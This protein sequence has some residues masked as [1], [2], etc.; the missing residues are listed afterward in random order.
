VGI[1]ATGLRVA[2]VALAVAASAVAVPDPPAGTV[3]EQAS[4]TLIEIPVNVLGRDGLPISGLEAKDFELFVD[5]KKEAPNAVEAIDLAAQTPAETPAGAGAAVPASAR[6]LWLLV[7]D[8]SYTSSSGLIRAR[9]GARHFVSTSMPATDLAAVGTLSIDTGWKLLVNF[10]RDRPQLEAAIATLGLPGLAVAS[11]DPLGFA[12][13][14]PGT[15]GS[16][17]GGLASGGKGIKEADVEEALRE[18][19]QIQR[20]SSDEQQRARVGKLMGSLG[21]IGR[22]LDS[23]RGRKHVVYF[24]EGFDPR[25][26]A[27]RSG[28]ASPGSSQTQLQM[29]SSTGGAL[30]PGTTLGANEA[31]IS[32]EIWKVDSDARFGSSSLQ[33]R[34]TS[35]LGLLGRSDAVLDAI[36][37]GGL[38]ADGD[39]AGARVSGTDSLAA[40]ASETGG[41][42]VRNANS[43]GEELHRVAEKTRRVYLLVYQPKGASKPG[44]F[45]RLRVAVKAPGAHV[46][47]RSGYYEPRPYASLTPL[48]RLLASGDLLTG[49]PEGET[50]SGRLVTAPFASP[51]DTAQVPVVVELPGKTL[52]AGDKADKSS[53]QVYAY[54]ND[55]SGALADY[56][57]SEAVLDLGKTRSALESGGVKFY[58]T[59]HLPAGEYR[60]RVLARNASTG[61]A[62]VWSATVSVPR[63]PGGAPSVLPPFF[64]EPP[65]RWVMIRARE[66]SDAPMHETDYPF[67]V[68]G[69][70]FIPAGLPDVPPGASARVI[71]CTYNF[72]ARAA[73]SGPL[74][75]QG[76]VVA[77]DGSSRPASLTLEKESDGERGGGRKLRLAF[78]T[79]GLARG[80]YRLDVSV[81]DP[82]SQ[83]SGRAAAAF[84]VP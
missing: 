27:G 56:V 78:R 6:R 39:A 60:I 66:R 15:L 64:E 25:L 45:H 73:S 59:L 12:F 9:E 80:T 83:A 53:V 62:G 35:S 46:F 37:I 22:V 75:V 50:L 51:S 31:A 54:A 34:M 70:A 68:G 61:R 82:A 63:M 79:D 29:G 32:G 74:A 5:D 71:V 10:T 41:D 49:G 52:L 24:S 14:P 30:D 77:A 16:S 23:V 4:A 84:E 17:G 58:G 69:E 38:R 3:R 21:A 65:G 40:M 43:L 20:Q 28:G 48:E 42:F 18:I 8:M 1:R 19:Q 76:T 72:G 2:A 67:A 13:Q 47:A 11:A 81:T 26:L 36:D 55:A 44:T 57:A 33:E 7:F